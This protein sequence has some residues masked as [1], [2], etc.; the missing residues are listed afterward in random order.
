MIK[1]Y[2]DENYG[3]TCELWSGSTK[4]PDSVFYF[5]DFEISDFLPR[6]FQVYQWLLECASKLTWPFF[7]H[8]L[9]QTAEKYYLWDKNYYMV[10]VFTEGGDAENGPKVYENVELILAKSEEEAVSLVSTHHYMKD[11]FI[12]DK[13]DEDMQFDTF[14]W[15]RAEKLEFT[16]PEINEW[17]EGMTDDLPFQQLKQ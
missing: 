12:V 14:D 8:E 17:F 13:Y 10:H 4:H 5:S 2:E 3:W 11:R 16:A 7:A 15:I 9:V 1:I 6:E